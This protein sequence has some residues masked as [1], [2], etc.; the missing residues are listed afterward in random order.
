MAL[1]D[2]LNSSKYGDDMVIA[3][4]DGS[5]ATFGELR[6]IEAEERSK[7][8]ERANLLGQAEVEFAT[9]FQQAVG[10]IQRE[11][12]VE[13][14]TRR[15]AAAAAYG[16]DEN[17]PLLGQV[18][19]EMKRIETEN[20]SKFTEM[21]KQHEAQVSKLSGIVAKVTGEYLNDNYA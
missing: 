3:L 14:T 17:D 2:V 7:L 16:L 20:A 5:S 19:R 1:K 18:V 9:R 15:A 4:P 8:N 11:A 21:Q 6:A 13:D 12:P 10:S